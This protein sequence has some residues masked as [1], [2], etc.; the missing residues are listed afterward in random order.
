MIPSILVVMLDF[1][2]CSLLLFVIGT[3]G[4]QTQFATAAPAAPAVHEEYGPAAIAAQQDQWNRDYEQQLLLTQL[5]SQ[6][7][8]NEQLRGHLTETAATLANKEQALRAVTEEKAR[9]EQAKAQTQQAL[10]VVETKLSTTETKL[11]QVSGDREKLQQEHLATTENLAKLQGNLTSLQAQQTRLQQEK[12]DL[13]QRAKQLDMTVASQQATIGML[14]EEVRASQARMEAG[15]TGVAHDQQQMSV[16]LKQLDEFAK[17]LPSAIQTN[18]ASFHDEQR[19][20]QD[21]LTAIADAI[22]GL[23]ADLQADERTGLMQAVAGVARGQQ[24]LQSRLENLI[25]SGNGEQLAQSLNTIQSGQESLRQQTAKL[26]DQIE[27]IKARG[28]GPFKAVK[29]ARLELLV[30][31]AKRNHPTATLLQFKSAAYPPLVLVGGRS[32]IVANYFTLGLGWSGVVSDGDPRGEIAELKCTI[33]R[34][35]DT[36]WAADLIVPACALRADPRVVTMELGGAIPG[37][38]TMDLAGPDALFPNGQQKMHVFKST[39]A[40]LSFEVDASPD[41]SD[42]RYLVLRRS[43]RGVAAWFENPAYRAEAGDYV[44][45]ADGKLVGIMVNRDHCFVL[46]K[47]NV[48]DCTLSIPLA[49]KKEFLRAARQF[50]KIKVP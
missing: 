23:Q 1:L 46:S 41:L 30:A 45:T 15:L 24:D 50:P 37:L 40:G 36:P 5:H 2:V 22:R 49:D 29:G 14:T 38:N 48:M 47:E 10:R 3:G 31:I 34:L 12:A 8:E 9:V 11:T 16:T 43:L 39:A 18:V 44:V 27:T 6:S 28:P 13:Q 19:A 20:L 7:T 25:K 17:T 4:K 42:A 32:F 35:G 21:N 33:G 26:A